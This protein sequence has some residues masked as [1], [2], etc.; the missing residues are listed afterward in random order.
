[1]KKQILYE[2]EKET[3]DDL[4]NFEN[5]RRNRGSYERVETYED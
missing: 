4:A 3:Q 2:R 5:D 1:M